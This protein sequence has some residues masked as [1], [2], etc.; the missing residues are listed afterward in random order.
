MRNAYDL[1]WHSN[2]HLYVPTNGTA[3]GANTPGVTANADGTFEANFAYVLPGSYTVDLDLTREPLGTGKDG[4]PV[5]LADIWP[6]A[7]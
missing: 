1:V 5:Y 4:K 3:G 6:S 2:G 7:V